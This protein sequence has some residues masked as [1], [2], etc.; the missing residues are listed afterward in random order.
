MSILCAAGTH[1]GLVMR[2]SSGG[3][4]ML[5]PTDEPMRTLTTKGHQSLI[6]PSAMIAEYY[7]AGRARPVTLPLGTWST[8]DRFGLVERTG[9]VAIDDCHFRMLEP[10]R[11]ARR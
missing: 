2:N 4:E 1:H 10:T 7:G 9:A 3:A 6:E 11:S 5:T 8:R